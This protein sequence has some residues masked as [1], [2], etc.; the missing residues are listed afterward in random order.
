MHKTTMTHVPM[1]PT[2]LKRF[3]KHVLKT[4]LVFKDTGNG[5]TRHA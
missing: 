4:Q 2:Q 1:T 5:G 3:K